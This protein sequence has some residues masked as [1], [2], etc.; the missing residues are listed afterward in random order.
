MH[1]EH[2]MLHIDATGGLVKIDKQM[3]DYGQ[4]LNYGFLLKDMSDLNDEAYPIC[5]VA[6]SRHNTKSI[7][8]MCSLSKKINFNDYL[9]ISGPVYHKDI[10]HWSLFFINVKEET[11]FY[12]DPMYSK[13]PHCSSV[14]ANWLK[15]SND[16]EEFSSFQW[17]HILLNN[18]VQK[19]SF[20]CGIF[21]CKFF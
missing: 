20:S 14:F 9:F 10:E 6:T 13:S 19:D 3:R 21:V 17:K 16:F 15:V 8:D 18:F 5:E 1:R 2:R 11:V 7:F 12:L 4:I